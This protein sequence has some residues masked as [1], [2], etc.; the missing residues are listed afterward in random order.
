VPLSIL[1]EFLGD[2]TG[3]MSRVRPMAYI[4]Q[5]HY[6]ATLTAE[7]AFEGTWRA[8]VRRPEG[9]RPLIELGE[10]S[11]VLN[12][13]TWADTPAVWGT[14]S[15]GRTLLYVE[16]PVG[17]LSGLWSLAGR[18]IIDRE[19]YQVRLLP[20]AA[21]TFELSIP[22]GWRL[23]SSVGFVRAPQP[24]TR[25][26]WQVW[27]I[28]LG[29]HSECVWTL[30][31]GDSAAAPVL[32]CDRTIIYSIRPDG[33]R[34]QAEFA[35]QAFAQPA[36]ELHFLLPAELSNP[37]VTY[38]TAAN[39]AFRVVP[40]RGLQRLIVPLPNAEPGRLGT[41]RITADLPAKQNEDAPLPVVS[42]DGAEVLRGSR[43]VDVDR[44]LTLKSLDIDGLRQSAVNSDDQGTDWTFDELRT[45]GRIVVHVGRPETS[46]TSH[47]ATHIEWTDEGPRFHAVVSLQARTGSTFRTHFRMPQGCDI[48]DVFPSE[49]ILNYKLSRWRVAAAGDSEVLTVEFRQALQVQSPKQFE[50]TGRWTNTSPALRVPA[51]PVPLEADDA[52]ILLAVNPGVEKT[53]TASGGALRS[54]AGGQIPSNWVPH[55]QVLGLSVADPELTWF[56]ADGALSECEISIKSDAR[57]TSHVAGAVGVQSGPGSPF[58]TTLS[59]RT[60]E[61]AL[62]LDLRSLISA[63]GPTAHWH[64]ARYYTS[65]P[66]SAGEWT[67]DLPDPAVLVAV[68]VND[69]GHPVEVLDRV[70][71]LAP[72]PPDTHEILVRYRTPATT[73]GA[74]WLR[75][76]YRVPLPRW[77]VPVI[78]LRWS[79]GL[80]PGHAVACSSLGQPAE[81]RLASTSLLRQVFAPWIRPVNTPRFNPLHSADWRTLFGAPVLLPEQV[82]DSGVE[83]AFVSLAPPSEL[84][85]DTWNERTA[86]QLMQAL[87]IACLACVVVIRRVAGRRARAVVIP[88]AAATLLTALL[89]PENYAPL[90]GGCLLGLIAGGLLPSCWVH[91]RDWLSAW[92][93]SRRLVA[94]SAAGMATLAAAYCVRD[95]SARA[96][97]SGLGAARPALPTTLDKDSSPET[98]E[99][100]VLVPYAGAEIAPVG[101]IEAHLIPGFTDWLQREYELP[102]YLLRSVE[103]QVSDSDPALV[104]AVLDVAVLSAARHIAVSLP[105]REIAFRSPDDCEVD[106]RRSQVR[107]T[108]AGNGFVVDVEP[109]LPGAEFKSTAR[110]TAMQRQ[111]EIA[112]WFRMVGGNGGGGYRCRVPSVNSARLH[113]PS[114]AIARNFRLLSA[115]GTQHGDEQGNLDCELG[116]IDWI[117]IEPVS[118]A[119]VMDP[120]HTPVRVDATTLVEVHPMRLQVRTRIDVS[121]RSEEY[122]LP[123]PRRLNLLLPGRA[124]VRQVAAD[125]LREFNV[126]HADAAVTVLEIS[127]NQPLAVRQKIEFDYAVPFDQRVAGEIPAMP[128]LE[129]GRLL[130]HHIGLRAAPGMALE[131]N[132]SARESDHLQELVPDLFGTGLPADTVWSPPDS[133]FSALEPTPIPIRLTP[134]EPGRTVAVERSVTIDAHSLRVEAQVHIDISGAPVFEHQLGVPLN[135]RIDALSVEQD[136][137]NRL[138]DW[139]RD[140]D[141]LVVHLREGR[142]GQQLL[143]LRGWLPLQAGEVTRFPS[144]E[145]EAATTRSSELILRNASG[146]GVEL[147]AEA[148]TAALPGLSASPATSEA[149]IRRYAGTGPIVPVS[150]RMEDGP[151]APN[152]HSMAFLEKR[153]QGWFLTIT[154]RVEPRVDAFPIELTLHIPRELTRRFQVTPADIVHASHVSNDGSLEMHLQWQDASAA[155]DGFQMTASLT[156]HEESRWTVPLPSFPQSPGSRPFLVLSPGVPYAPDEATAVLIDPSESIPDRREWLSPAVADGRAYR[157]TADHVTLVASR[158]A[159]FTPAT[160]AFAETIVWDQADGS[161]IGLTVVYLSAV[162]RQ[163]ELT[164]ALPRAVRLLETLDGDQAVDTDKGDG[165]TVI[166]AI[167]GSD[168]GELHRVA[169]L[170]RRSAAGFDAALS[171]SVQVPDFKDLR[172]NRHFV[173]VVPPRGRQ[174]FLRGKARPQ[175]SDDYRL[176]RSEQLLQLVGGHRDPGRGTSVASVFDMA[177]GLD[178]DIALLSS[179]VWSDDQFARRYSVLR[180]RWNAVRDAIGLE[181]DSKSRPDSAY[182]AAVNVQIRVLSEVLRNPDAISFCSVPGEQQVD[183]WN[184]RVATV[185]SV[186]GVLFAL[187]LLVLFVAWRKLLR[188]WPGLEFGQHVEYLGLGLIGLI[189]WFALRLGPLGFMF[190]VGAAVLQVA[191]WL[192]NP[193]QPGVSRE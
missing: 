101:F 119:A 162:N 82:V 157:I 29:R 125:S 89:L 120:T 171:T 46:L 113:L 38:S 61:P 90:A 19:E 3:P 17:K 132:R 112:V 14:D 11:P 191:R 85:L 114:S 1:N 139:S 163:I 117:G 183:F 156:P 144:L 188:R 92:Q 49:N 26:G 55:R 173:T 172:A 21:S 129:R 146:L 91:Q 166:C 190:A 174:Y 75:S 44:P 93:P 56:A 71:K 30:H 50:I 164:L 137:A 159:P 77:N 167:Q 128:L 66:A 104:R 169:F 80:P 187:T 13:L 121:P 78:N 140:G 134:L 141:R 84:S 32:M 53:V 81:P 64:E 186:G 72:L 153:D 192:P 15:F 106:G 5:A 130:S 108:A 110:A 182:R 16:Q 158:A 10:M 54:I 150:C 116:G 65:G 76:R 25:E 62:S 147:Y 184:L 73:S 115:Q 149:T 94:T 70:V 154:C 2:E 148:G 105:F 7:L 36:R 59:T 35:I 69:R 31:R 180:E 83:V 181:F 23:R 58:S 179:S 133:A 45:D 47:V 39:L 122:G 165:S 48:V 176:E 136:D 74:G 51:F 88:A 20:S 168:T 87:L 185:R 170:W 138:L 96:Q 40:D 34:V 67:F 86:D 155:V 42:L 131:P 98:G 124:E 68:F 43:R 151:A 41:F 160:S 18:S 22:T 100:D 161:A 12:E 63:A 102:P 126:W 95:A 6:R 52:Q 118:S 123:L 4:E 79:V 142:T 109:A 28:E 177:R 37:T 27:T 8:T 9:S 143:K 189:W 127:F 152:L 107:P 145:F 97:D 24:A 111:V 135:L 33:N 175:R 193:S 60:T 99:F 57:G 103:Y 178:A